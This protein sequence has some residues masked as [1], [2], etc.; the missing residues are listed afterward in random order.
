P[1]TGNHD[2][3]SALIR[4]R[5]GLHAVY[6]QNFYTRR[7][8]AARG[9]TLVGYRGTLKFDWYQDELTVHHHFSARVDRHRFEPLPGEGHHGG[10]AA[11]ARNFLDVIRGRARQRSP[12]RSSDCCPADRSRT[13]S[14]PSWASTT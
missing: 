5:S 3:A 12:S 1:D 9:V 11:L 6:T 10:D 14:R 4:Y 7:G 2:S 13:T 8:A